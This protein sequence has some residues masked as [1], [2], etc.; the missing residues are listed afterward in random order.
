MLASAAPTDVFAVARG[1]ATDL[2]ASDHGHQT[3]FHPQLARGVAAIVHRIS[4]GT[5]AGAVTVCAT[6]VRELCSLLD[7]FAP[8]L[9]VAMMSV[10]VVFPA[11]PLDGVPLALQCEWISWLAATQP[12]VSGF[13][14]A[15]AHINAARRF[16]E[17]PAPTRADGQGAGT[18]VLWSRA[19]ACALVPGWARALSPKSK[20]V[21]A[22]VA[23]T[24]RNLCSVLSE[25]SHAAESGTPAVSP[26]ERLCAVVALN[27]TV[28]VVRRWTLASG[29]GTR[30][31][32][33]PVPALARTG[34]QQE[35]LTAA[36][37]VLLDLLPPRC[38]GHLLEG[39]LCLAAAVGLS[40]LLERSP[41]TL[42]EI[43]AMRVMRAHGAFSARPAEQL[44]PPGFQPGPKSVSQRIVQSCVETCIP[45]CARARER[46]RH[47]CTHVSVNTLRHRD[48]TAHPRVRRACRAKA[49]RAQ[50][51]GWCSSARSTG[52][53]G[54]PSS[55]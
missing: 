45:V 41:S 33:A 13:R 15:E 21:G 1:H 11:L 30:A 42:H 16:L 18:P 17:A 4:D 6:A 35:L 39:S 32:A 47:S 28:S 22:Q 7:R 36:V 50:R 44:A 8:S 10:N 53:F 2:A 27:S 34:W 23:I 31:P 26:A 9:Q 14:E 40:H 37:H 49:W 38:A 54:I 51:L 48:H 43:E 24:V 3:D 46:A 19:L 20:H 29:D 12:R 25:C 5:G 55:R 52:R